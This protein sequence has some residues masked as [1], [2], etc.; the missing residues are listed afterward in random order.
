MLRA[1]GVAGCR[2]PP[3]AQVIGLTFDDGLDP[4]RNAKA[5]AWNTR[6]LNALEQQQLHAIVFPALSHIGGDAG[7]A[8]IEQWSAAGHGVGNHTAH[9]RSLSSSKVTLQAFIADVQQADDALHQLP[10][11]LPMLR[12]P[13]LKEGD[14]RDKRDGMREWMR[15]H[16]YRPAPVSID[17]SD[18]YYNQRYLAL[19]AAGRSEPVKRLKRAYVRHLL[20]RAAYYDNLARAVIG[21]SPAHVMLLH[22]NALNAAALPEV[23]EAFRNARLALRGRAHRVR[24]PAVCDAAD[25]AAGRREHPLGAGQGARRR[26]PALSRPKTRRT[27]GRCCSGRAW[28]RR[29]WRAAVRRGAGIGRDWTVSVKLARPWPSAS[30]T[31]TTSCCAWWI[32]PRMERFYCEVL[33]CSVEK[34][35]E[36][37]GLIQLRAGRSLLDLVP[38][39]GP[40]GRAGGAAPG[41]EGRN[42][43]H[44]CFRVEPFDEAAIRAQLQRFGVE[45]GPVEPRYG[46]EG[47]GPSIY[48]TDPEGNVVELK[49]PPPPG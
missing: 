32:W 45:A 7:M 44:F 30:A 47:E 41:R 18:W 33:G 25:D 2:W 28:R 39:D 40:L 10:T 27:S 38:V 37:I 15:E 34:R 3:A 1:A 49:G 21:R 9:H 29:A 11:W 24:G 36:A 8:L 22:T 35:Q 13:Y 12:F 46:A 43:D 5:E 6:I 48:I 16:G 26:W 19:L 31:S 14:T 4:A 42:L 23:I 20:D 17:T